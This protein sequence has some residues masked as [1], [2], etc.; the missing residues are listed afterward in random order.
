YWVRQV[1]HAVRFSDGMRSLR[2][3]GVNTFLELGPQPV[4]SGLGASCLADEGPVSWVASCV[5]GKDGVS[6]VQRSL[7]ELHVRGVP[8]DWSRFFAPFGGERVALPTYAF[9]RERFWF[10]PPLTREVGAGLDPTGHALLGG[11]VEIAGTELSLFTTV[12][13]AD[14]PVW[15]QEHRVMDAVLMPGTAFFEAMRAAGDAA[16]EGEW[17]LSDVVIA[18]PLVLAP[19]VPAR[20]QVTVGPGVGES[21]SVRVHSASEGEDGAWQL[22]AE[23]R[24]TP[25]E[26][27]GGAAVTVP[28]RGAEPLDAS[29][30]YSD[31]DALGYGYGPT[32]QGIKEAWH[33]GGEVWARAT[34]P[35]SAEQSAAGYVL[36]PALLDSAMHSLLLTQRL[37]NR[38][39]DDLFVPFEAERLSLRVKGLAEIWVRVA[40]FELGDGEFWASLDLHDA[41]GAHVGRL[42]RLHAR[43]VDRAVL[44]RLAAAG[45]DRFQFDVDWRPVDTADVELGGSWGLMTP[46]GDVP[47][48]R[49]AKAL[50]SRA[51]IQV[52]NVRDLEDAEDLDGLLCLWDSDAQVPAQAH[53]FAAKALEQLQ[54][55]VGKEF[56]APLVWVTRHAVGTG[57]DDMVSGLGA[58]PLWGLMRTARN[59]HPELGLRMID[60]G[61]EEA[62]RKALPAALMLEAEPECALRHGE[63]LVPHLARVGS[64]QD[65]QLPDEGRWQLEIAAKGRLDEPLTVTSL[66]ERPLAPGEI[67]AEVRAA[68]VNF[69]D[70]L[71]ALGMVEIPA[72]GLEFA[73]VVTEVGS[74]VDQVKVGDAVLGL[75]RGSFASEVVTDVRQVVRMPDHLTFEEAATIPM[76]FLTAWYGLHELGALRPG[77]KVLIHAAAGIPSTFLEARLA[78]GT[79]VVR[80]MPNTPVLVDEG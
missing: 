15:V 31:L 30:L 14:Q 52:I 3:A 5:P 26:G 17:D 13:A 61:D 50:L 24:I 66:P 37:Q 20:L 41:D 51:G 56:R 2:R 57:A 46:A 80:V 67:R 60:L 38:T 76:T 25:A 40:E 11:A 74:S 70:V 54:E 75:A 28:P 44:R 1:R 78:V 33:V 79:P 68:G 45:V 72:F 35:E 19:G 77:E 18:S 53:A 12:V 9:Q 7:A 64:A 32:F 65:L 55:A 8:V 36:H 4:L 23:G 10:E 49:E 22:H 71:N 29:A 42:H 58:G 6:V 16:D 63:V 34:L 69:L 43:R 62:D 47:W 39:G 27:A 73:G 21:R 59:E 48:A